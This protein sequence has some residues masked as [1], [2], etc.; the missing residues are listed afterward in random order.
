MVEAKAGRPQ[1]CESSADLTRRL[2]LFGQCVED[3][4]RT[5]AVDGTTTRRGSLTR[6]RPGPE[7]PTC[8]VPRQ[9]QGDAVSQLLTCARTRTPR[10]P[11]RNIQCLV[12]ALECPSDAHPNVAKELVSQGQ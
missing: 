8:S 3:G 2:V 5:D 12:W 9:F 7:A 6:E 1:L 4:R 10:A 11:S